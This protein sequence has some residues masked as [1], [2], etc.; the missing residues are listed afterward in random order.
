[1]RTSIGYRPSPLVSARSFPA[2][3][4]PTPLPALLDRLF[5]DRHGLGPPAH[6]PGRVTGAVSAPDPYAGGHR[7]LRV[8]LILVP[9][10]LSVYAFIDCLST[11]ERDIRYMPK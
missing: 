11:D 2:P 9:L 1:M 5:P 4:S 8:L 6:Y 10:G 7:M 3:A